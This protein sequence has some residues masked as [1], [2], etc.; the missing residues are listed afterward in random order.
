MINMNI[1]I[2]LWCASIDFCGCT[3]KNSTAG[4]Y[5]T[6]DFPGSYARLHF[7]VSIKR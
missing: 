3:S 6:S 1:Q 2:L 4:A 5:G 7:L